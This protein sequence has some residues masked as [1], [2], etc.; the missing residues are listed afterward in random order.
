M[1]AH[2][3]KRAMALFAVFAG[4]A[5]ASCNSAAQP[6]FAPFGA[7][8]PQGLAAPSMSPIRHVVVIVQENRTPDYLFQGIA[9]ADIAKY[10]ID[11]RG[12]RVALHPVSLETPW[13]LGHSHAGFVKDYDG[14]KMDGFDAGLPDNVHLRPFGY[15]PESE[16]RPYHEMASR[17]AFA[18]H[19]FETNQGPSFPAHLYIVSG[20]GT[21][22]RLAP[23][24]VAANPHSSQTGKGAPGGCDAADGVYV[25]TI[26]P[27]NAHVGPT[28]YP[29]FERPVLSDLLQAKHV[30]WHYYQ[31]HRGAGRWEAMD[32]YRNVR[33][34]RQYENVVW[35][36]QRVLSDI[37]RG[38]LADVSWVI[39]DPAWSDHAG[40]LGS[41]EGPAWVAAI[42][43]AI[44]ESA[45]WK[46]TAILLTW[47][48]W[49][50]WYDHV[51][52]PIYN[53]Y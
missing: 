44:G 18:D 2:L 15:G 20:S 13:D 26:D 50:G 39:P 51:A 30:S 48:D 8:A 7:P 10:A 53:K 11:S 29:C 32:A 40:K 4:A 47:D 35:P 34:S 25:Q 42:V 16:L 23:Y 43:N 33:Y 1:I 6:V 14:G 38:R 19:M 24:D 46:S 49:G 22:P 12:R 3:C 5:L 41:T 27:H 17:Y 37:K 21:D 28:P 36:S 52:P 45:Y 9:G 31:P